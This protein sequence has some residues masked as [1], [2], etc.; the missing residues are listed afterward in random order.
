MMKFSKGDVIAY[1]N[2]LYRVTDVDRTSGIFYAD[3]IFLGDQKYRPTLLAHNLDPVLSEEEIRERLAQMWQG[4]SELLDI[5]YAMEDMIS[6]YPSPVDKLVELINY[7]THPWIDSVILDPEEIK[8]NYFAGNNFQDVDN[9][10]RR[11]KIGFGKFLN[12]INRTLGETFSPK[13]ID[14][15]SALWGRVGSGKDYLLELEE[16]WEIPDLYPKVESCMASAL[17]EDGDNHLGIYALNPEKVRLLVCRDYQEV[18]IARALWWT[19]D[20]GRHLLDRIYPNEGRH[21]RW[22]QSWART[23]DPNAILRNDQ[24]AGQGGLEQHPPLRV[25]LKTYGYHGGKFLSILERQSDPLGYS[26]YGFPYVDTLCYASLVE[27]GRV[28]FSNRP[29]G[30]DL[31]WRKMNRTDGSIFLAPNCHRCGHNFFDPQ[32]P[33]LADLEL[34]TCHSCAREVRNEQRN[35][36][37]QQEQ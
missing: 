6:S 17:Y 21:V 15:L 10:R 29:L 26:M 18:V 22:M 13:E 28:V 7:P 9:P 34:P 1:Q 31:A 32:H 8:I 12:L 3:V 27:N 5:L 33:D 36:I 24:K 25:T 37:I 19:L 20:D 23:Q 30:E 14:Q 4:K 2:R 11:R 16:G 35:V